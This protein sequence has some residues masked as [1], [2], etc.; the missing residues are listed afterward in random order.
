[1]LRRSVLL[2]ALLSLFPAAAS[3][4]SFAAFGPHLGFSSSPDQVV[5]GGHLQWVDVAPKLDFVPSVDLGFGDVRDRVSFN[6]D[7]HY[8]LD[9]RTE[10][11]PYIG[12]GV[13]IHSMGGGAKGGG[14]FLAGADV[15]TKGRSRFFAE[16]KLAFSDG[17]D[18][19]ATAGWSFQNR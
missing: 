4:E 8:R 11:Q 17:P 7:F 12:G 9:A 10:W 5:F 19:Q 13:G 2:I 6:G 1:M 16:I 3:A 15:A 14:H 18:L